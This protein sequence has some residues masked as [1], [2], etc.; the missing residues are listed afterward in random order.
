MTAPP[1]NPPAR[2]DFRRFWWAEAGSTFG[3]ACTATAVSAVAVDQLHAQ[4]WELGLLTA[5]AYLPTLLLGPRAGRFADETPR[6]RRQLVR[7]DFLALLFLLATCAAALHGSLSVAWLILLE[8]ALGTVLLVGE[9]IYFTHL[10]TLVPPGELVAA[11]ARLQAGTSGATIAGSSVAG[12]LLAAVGGAAVFAL[13]AFTYLLSALLLTGIRAPDT[14]GP[15]PPPGDT[16]RTPPSARP[17]FTRGG[18]LRTTLCLLLVQ[19]LAAGT[20]AALLA[21]LLLREAGLPLTLFGLA[22]STTGV[23]G[24]LGAWGATRLRPGSGPRT[25]AICAL[26]HVIGNSLV[27]CASGTPAT[28]LAL[29]AAG[30]MTAKGA[31]AVAN[32]ALSEVITT[33]APP[34][35]LGRTVA[36]LRTS[37]TVCQITGALA[38][39][40]AATAGGVRYVMLA[41]ALLPL[42][43]LPLV[44]TFLTRPDPPRRP[45]HARKDPA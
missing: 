26:V 27:A 39:G 33:H 32:V 31:G 1:P 16:D 3:T 37:S 19:A 21:P 10:Q 18:P 38:G 24:V 8:L 4:G 29:A 42:A 23:A 5:C 22:L 15:A 35:L 41:A 12:L 45:R 36:F 11:R 7:G 28:A 44:A 20:T 14:A 2:K 17:L 34:H 43:A 40:V 13:D 25:L 6:P 30:L 9:T